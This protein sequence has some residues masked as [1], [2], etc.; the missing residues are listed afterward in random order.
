METISLTIEKPAAGGRMIARLDGQ[1]VLVA[2]A[3]P[4]ERVTARVDRVGKGVLYA[5]TIGV[6]SASPDRRPVAGD[7]ECG[8]C[9]Y[10]HVDYPRQLALKSE[11]IADAYARIAKLALPARVV[12]APSPEAGYRMRARLH[13]R[14]QRLGFFREGTHDICD[15]RATRQL[16]PATCDALDRLAAGV[17]SL[18]LDVR[19]IEL[20]ENVDASNRAVC[21]DTSAAIDVQST[22][23]L[24]ATDGVTSFGPDAVVH[25]TLSIGGVDVSLRRSVLAFFQGNR[26]LLAA[27][28]NH[29]VDEVPVDASL[30]DLYAG[31]GLF[32]VG[33]AAAKKSRVRAVEGDRVSAADLIV[34]AGA[35]EAVDAVRQPVETFLASAPKTPDVL[36]VDPPRTG[37]SRDALDGIISLRAPQMIYVS[38]DVATL[39]RDSKRLVESGY[40]ITRADAFDLFPNTPHVETVVRFRRV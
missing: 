5:T 16:L 31:A 17:R 32:A 40:E 12:V 9:L 15:A 4:G 23:R 35:Y 3:I 26:Y 33:A 25:E 24:G 39:A 20:S 21:L 22:A 1:V 10:A 30:V 28:V 36:V 37:M 8:G 38:C 13:V 19:E 18:G 34:N 29:V 2:G 14:G 27:L 11:V 7:P 6:E